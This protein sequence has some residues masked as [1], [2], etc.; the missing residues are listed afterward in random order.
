MNFQDGDRV[1]GTYGN[2]WER[3]NQRWHLGVSSV[4]C[5]DETMEWLLNLEVK[6]PKPSE[7]TGPQKLSKSEK[8]QPP[9][10]QYRYTYKPKETS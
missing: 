7:T 3:R 1:V 2:I 6:Y 5:S 10:Y 9:V 4:D 8:T